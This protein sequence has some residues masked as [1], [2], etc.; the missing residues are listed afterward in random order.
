MKKLELDFI[1][2][3]FE[4]EG[5]TLLT[6]VYINNKQKLEYI[7]PNG[8]QHR[9]SWNEWSSMHN[10]CLYCSGNAK[11]NIGD[12]RTSFESEGFKLLSGEYK[13]GATKLKY[14]C[15]AGHK[16]SIRWPDWKKGFRCPYCSGKAKKTIEFISSEFEREGYVLISNEYKN[17]HT[18]F[19]YACPLGH[20]HETTWAV[21]SRGK[22][23]PT[24]KA[25]RLS[26]ESSPHWKGGISSLPYCDSWADKEYKNDIKIRD[27][28]R[29]LNPYCEGKSNRLSIHHIDYD[30]QNCTPTNLITL[31]PSC[32]TKAN[33][34]R[35]W[36]K[37]WYRAIMYQRY[38]YKY[39]L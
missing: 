29:C 38:G 30:K 4:L 19:E 14:I 37:H 1:K 31:C 15:P 33:I 10:R 12:I 3:E 13:N 6:K 17:C 9:I 39:E 22:R 26:G 25:I 11:P 18:K 35:N 21:W 7:C 23:C 34:D 16:H 36:H 24:C 2:S 27:G 20:K 8:H 28:N 32:N 5:Y